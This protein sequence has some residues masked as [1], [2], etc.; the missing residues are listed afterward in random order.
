MR[1]YL[2]S[3]IN[4]LILSTIRRYLA[5][6]IIYQSQF[7]HDWWQTHYHDVHATH[8][9]IYNGVDLQSFT[10]IGPQ[11]PPTDIIRLLVIEGSFKGGHKRDLLNAVE[12]ANG[13]QQKAGSPLELIIAGQ[14]P[15]EL[16]NS[17]VGKGK[18]RINWI[19]LIPNTEIP[20]LNRS[21]H[22]LF[23]AEI[24]AACPNSVV[25]ALACGLPVVAYATGSLPELVDGDAGRVAPYGSDYWHL[26]A[27]N[28]TPLIAG[29]LEILANQPHFRQAARARAEEHFSL[30]KMTEKYLRALDL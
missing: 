12:F 23:P 10:P 2:R 22:M 28:P 4:N 15:D 26:E 17:V 8:E 11:T 5:E 7:T 18:L 29:A 9:V 21:A 3:E 16:K 24:N 13:L 14:V 25:E 27:P 20:L 30:E 6:H 1:H 19:G